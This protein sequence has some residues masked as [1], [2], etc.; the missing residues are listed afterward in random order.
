MPLKPWALYGLSVICFAVVFR[1]H[2]VGLGALCLL[3]A[4]VSM[5]WASLVL[6]QA[7]IESRAQ[8]PGSLLGP[9]E[10]ARIRARAEAERA[11]Q[12]AAPDAGESAS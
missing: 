5:V 6:M 9:E 8:D 12:S 11:R 10:L 2:S 3:V 1:T 7:R 4:L